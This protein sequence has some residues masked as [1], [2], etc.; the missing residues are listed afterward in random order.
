M[1]A[2][3]P[4]RTGLSPRRAAAPPPRNADGAAPV[5]AA[6]QA[7]AARRTPATASAPGSVFAAVRALAST[8]PPAAAAILQSAFG[9][10]AIPPPG[11]APGPATE[12]ERAR[13][14][15]PARAPSFATGFASASTLATTAHH[16]A[17]ISAAPAPAPGSGSVPVLVPARLKAP[18][19]APAPL[20]RVILPGTPDGVR[21]ALAGVSA[22]LR[23][24]P[25][26]G[27]H[28]PGADHESDHAAD[29]QADDS[30]IELVLAEVL[31][32]IVEHAYSDGVGLITLDLRRAHGRL[33]CLLRDEG[34]PMPAGRLPP[35]FAPTLASARADLPEGGFGWFL[36]RSLTRDLRY[37]REPGC[38]RLSFSIPHPIR[39]APGV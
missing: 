30:T 25:L 20:L 28:G 24:G 18:I 34:H 27:R 35:G 22:A 1:G 31:N 2:E 29:H 11:T 16:D 7:P 26:S 5:P 33:C 15:P 8:A 10:A 19:S 6:R 23:S 39:T 14:A 9:S 13:A 36:I 17:A 38:N 37:D 3:P 21:L 12:P 32:N 4:Q